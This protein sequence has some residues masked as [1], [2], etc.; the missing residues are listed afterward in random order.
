MAVPMPA[1]VAVA[2]LFFAATFCTIF[3]PPGPLNTAAWWALL[4]LDVLVIGYYVR[5][6]RSAR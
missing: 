1:K 3:M 2:V 4:P 5:K 6:R